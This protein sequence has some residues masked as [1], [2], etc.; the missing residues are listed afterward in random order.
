MIRAAVLLFVIV[1]AAFSSTAAHAEHA[2]SC[3][4]RDHSIIDGYVVV[5]SATWLF[6]GKCDGEDMWSSWSVTGTTNPPD[7]FVRPWLDYPIMA[8]G[9]EL[10]KLQE[11]V[12]W[13]HAFLMNRF[14]SWF[15]L[16]ST[17][18]PDAL[19]TLAPGETKA[20]GIWP[21]G[22]GQPWPAKQD[23]TSTKIDQVNK[24][25]APARVTGDLIDLHGLCFG[26]GRI[27]IFL[28]LYYTPASSD[29]S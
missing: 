14:V 25:G 6:A 22:Y 11:P 21:R 8:I 26:G 17:I 16:G 5:C 12:L 18:Q 24:D 1:S 15:T 4:N 23:A 9:Y 2:E 19:T 10:T 28:K 13:P 29:H 7:A 27:R 20:G 3:Q